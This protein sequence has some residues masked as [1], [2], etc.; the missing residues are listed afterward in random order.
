MLFWKEEN[1]LED[2]DAISRVVDGW[3]LLLPPPSSFVILLL[4]LFSSEKFAGVIDGIG[5]WGIAGTVGLLD[6]I[7]LLTAS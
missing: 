1:E 7:T 4:S 6:G 5:I 2:D 3:G